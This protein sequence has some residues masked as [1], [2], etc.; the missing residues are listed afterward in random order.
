MWIVD[1]KGHVMG[2][3]ML[4]EMAWHGQNL[5]WKEQASL[6]DFILYIQPRISFSR[7]RF[8]GC[9]MSWLSVSYKHASPVLMDKC[10]GGARKLPIASSTKN[11]LCIVLTL[12]ILK[13][14]SELRM[15]SFHL[16]ELRLSNAARAIT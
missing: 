8:Q 7:R 14:F 10:N 3:V 1:R 5:I 12:I 13:P 11:R 16:F 9:D 6:D 4:V 15:H 2:L